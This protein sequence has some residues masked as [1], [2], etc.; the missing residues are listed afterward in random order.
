M[1]RVDRLSSE[2][3]VGG[4]VDSLGGRIDSRWSGDEPR[5]EAYAGL[6]ACSM[7]HEPN[8]LALPRPTLPPPNRV[9]SRRPRNQG[10]IRTPCRNHPRAP[11]AQPTPRDVLATKGS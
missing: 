4:R 11:S 3:Y 2:L 5:S 1:G 9:V 6:E 10:V 7:S 8:R